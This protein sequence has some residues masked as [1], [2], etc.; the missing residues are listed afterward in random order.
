MTMTYDEIV[1]FMKEYFPAYS[2]KGQIKETQHVMNKFYAPD[3]IFD[4][5]VITSREQW[6][7]ACLS[8]PD[9]QDKITLEHL[10]VDEKQQEAVA[11]V[12][13]QA[14]ERSTDKVLVEIKMNV[15]YS[16]KSD[17]N[18]DIKISHIKVFLESNPQKGFD[19]MRTYGMKV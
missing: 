5:G 8:H 3:I 4:D 19:L 16:L 1:K 15:A 2:E 12:K 11:L 6:Y 17:A 10:I 9:I 14:I 13:T 7:K 18:G